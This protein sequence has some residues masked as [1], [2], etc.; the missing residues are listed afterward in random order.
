MTLKTKVNSIISY[1]EKW[2]K[3]NVEREKREMQEVLFLFLEREPLLSRFAGNPTVGSLR[4]KKESCSTRRGF[5]MG[6]GFEEFRQTPRDRGFSL[7]EFYSLFK[8][9]V[10]V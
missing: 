5:R 1:I 6:T 9:Y 10:N 7:L 8:I 4:D 2:K 3:E